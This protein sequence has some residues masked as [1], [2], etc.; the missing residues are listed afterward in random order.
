MMAR[1]L[2]KDPR[3]TQLEE[4]LF[5]N[6]TGIL[7]KK[8]Y[9]ARFSDVYAFGFLYTLSLFFFFFPKKERKSFSLNLSKNPF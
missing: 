8:E 2:E 5:F 3:P 6:E 1:F 4:C 7:G 9:W